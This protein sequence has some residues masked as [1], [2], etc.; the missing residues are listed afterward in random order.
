MAK[1]QKRIEVS[2]GE[3]M[4]YW[5]RR[6]GDERQR[7][8]WF[9]AES[10]DKTLTRDCCVMGRVLEPVGYDEDFGVPYQMLRFVVVKRFYIDP[11][12]PQQVAGSG[13][14]GGLDFEEF[15]RREDAR[16]AAEHDLLHCDSKLQVA[17]SELVPV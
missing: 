8:G 5:P 4:C 12:R 2:P 10:S 15:L 13:L 14:K 11:K 7:G 9:K 17:H 3:L 16:V 1:E 6:G